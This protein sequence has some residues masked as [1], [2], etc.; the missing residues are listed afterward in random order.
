MPFMLL[1]KFFCG[2]NVSFG[3]ADFTAWHVRR[4]FYSFVQNGK[5]V[6]VLFDVIV[7]FA[8][9]VNLLIIFRKNRNAGIVQVSASMQTGMKSQMFFRG[10]F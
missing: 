7:W 8:E 1:G 9:K 2:F 3:S 10:C 4:M 6:Y 5:R